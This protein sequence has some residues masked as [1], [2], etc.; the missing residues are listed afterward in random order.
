MKLQAHSATLL[1][2]SLNLTLVEVVLVP[3]L[4]WF[5]GGPKEVEEVW[6]LLGSF[7]SD[8][9]STLSK[10]EAVGNGS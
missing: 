8:S 2:L 10:G 7:P 4:P 5:P 6:V 3:K 1:K 9:L